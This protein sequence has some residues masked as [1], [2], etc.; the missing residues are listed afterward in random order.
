[1]NSLPRRG[2]PAAPPARIGLK[3]RGQTAKQSPFPESAPLEAEPTGIGEST[4]SEVTTLNV[5]VRDRVGKGAARAARREGLVPGVIYGNKLPPIAVSVEPR[6]LWAEMNKPGFSTRLFDV[7]VDGKT[8][9]VLC[10]D[11]QRH[12]VNE[13][14]VHVDF[15]R[16]SAESRLH[17]HVPVHF[18][19]H[20]KSPGIKRG[21][22]LNVV[23][24]ELELVAPANAIPNSVV[25]DLT[26]LEIGASIHLSAVVL[27]VGVTAVTHEKNPTL[28]TIAAPTTSASTADEA[29]AAPAAEGTAPASA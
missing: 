25:I 28:A 4:M 26:G 23:A 24:H 15:L 7:A 29:A 3:I 1:V 2:K 13:R 11:V 20:D 14:P 10:R 27:P 17:V 5:S 21:G 8:E 22:V 12:P 19:N 9:R 18:A 16:V 6:V